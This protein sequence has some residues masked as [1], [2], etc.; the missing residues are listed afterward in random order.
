MIFRGRDTMKARRLLTIIAAIMFIITMTACNNAAP[1]AA[2]A[3]ANDTPAATAPAADAD[4]PVKIAYISKML[5]HP[6]FQGTDN[7]LRD[8]AAKLGVD[9]FSIDADLSDEAF[10]AA[11]E[12]AFAQQVDGLTITITNQGNGPSV[13]QRVRD[14]GVALL[15]IDDDIIDENGDPVPHVGATT[16]ESGVMG[17]EYLARMATERGFFD[18][19]NVVKAMFIDAPTVTVLW[20]RI[21]GYMEA[22][23]ANTPLTEDDILIPETSDAMLEDSLVVARATIQAHPEVTHWIVGGVNDDTAIA[24]LKAIEEEGRIPLENAVF[25]GLGGYSMSVEEFRRGNDSYICIVWDSYAEGYKAMEIM[26]DYLANGVPMPM[27]TLVGGNIA[28]VDNWQD[29]IDPSNW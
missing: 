15:T 24:P 10:D 1:P 13:A 7:G 14:R 20:P 18:E 12:N 19:G 6:W 26:Y 4:T 17:G 5:S 27:S 21:E 3:P 9:Y 29:I 11:L 23:L 2:E 25:C 22:I 28:T 8:A 16:R